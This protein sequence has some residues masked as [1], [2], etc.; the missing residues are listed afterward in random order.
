[1]VA[2]RLRCE[3]LAALVES[4]IRQRGLRPGDRFDS[5]RTVARSF[6]VSTKAANEALRLL[7]Q[8]GVLVRRQRSGAF[9]GRA[10]GVQG[11]AE[12]IRCV[13]LLVQTGALDLLAPAVTELARGVRETCPSD[14]VQFACIP[15]DADPRFAEDYLRIYGAGGRLVG[16]VLLLSTPP[17]QRAFYE[18]GLP[19][20]VI[21]SP[22]PENSGIPALDLD[23]RE[24]GRLLL[25]AA[26]K[27]RCTRI[28]VILLN[29]WVYGDNLLVDGMRE[30]LG[31]A[32]A[33]GTAFVLR[34][35]DATPESVAAGV[36]ELTGPPHR[37][38]ILICRT[39]RA[40]QWAADALR[41]QGLHVPGDV[42]LLAADRVE[43]DLAGCCT[44]IEPELSRV[45]MGR[46][47]GKLLAR[48][49]NEAA[50]Q[51]P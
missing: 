36:R 18:T 44:G 32:G 48:Q 8:R 23:W 10:G 6:G 14:A 3:E 1:M 49:I 42:L 43:G 4:E 25:A 7:V 29:R 2:R 12:G 39:A 17:M 35:V 16:V 15:T 51:V 26:R 37:A 31:P 47:A 9:V 34:S 21:G 24:H 50:Q 41:T 40:A 30:A 11:Q 46:S 20:V 5:T 13:H 27:K 28:G 22:P 33:A 19:T 45:E 38:Q